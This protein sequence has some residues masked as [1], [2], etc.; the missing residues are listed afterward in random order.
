[1]ESKDKT[2]LYVIVSL[3]VLIVGTLIVLVCVKARND[4]EDKEYEERMRF[5]ENR[6]AEMFRSMDRDDL[7]GWSLSTTYVFRRDDAGVPHYI[8]D[9]EYTPYRTW[10]LERAEVA[11]DAGKRVCVRVYPYIQSIGIDRSVI[12]RWVKVDSIV[13]L[14]YS[15]IVVYAQGVRMKIFKADNYTYVLDADLGSCRVNTSITGKMLTG[16]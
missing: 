15:D 1:M 5:I 8:H 4:R 6:R 2:S 10:E 16:N 9:T 3:V 12:G 14:D 11:L 13:R 7:S